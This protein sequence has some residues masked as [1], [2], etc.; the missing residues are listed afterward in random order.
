MKMMSEKKCMLTSKADQLTGF[1]MCFDD[2]EETSLVNIILR[3][4]LKNMQT[5]DSGFSLHF[6]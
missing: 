4:F 2:K 3:D 5:L 6:V 1:L